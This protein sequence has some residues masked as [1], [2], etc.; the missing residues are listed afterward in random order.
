MAAIIQPPQ[1]LKRII[2]KILG[3]FNRQNLTRKEFHGDLAYLNDIPSLEVFDT[4]ELPQLIG[5]T[6]TNIKQDFGF[7]KIDGWLDY[8]KSFYEIDGSFLISFSYSGSWTASITKPSKKAKKIRNEFSKM[9]VGQQIANIYFEFFENKPDYG[10]PIYIELSN[11]LVLWESI[12]ATH[13]TG[14]ANLN[15]YTS[16]I[17]M[18]RVNDPEVDIRSIKILQKPN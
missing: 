12:M 6:V 7:N 10:E 18:E 4:I 13:G 16:E 5:K 11:G 14:G 1:E 2:Q 9:I 8:S 15:M 3:L 17:F